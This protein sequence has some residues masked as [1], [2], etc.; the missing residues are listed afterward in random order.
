[1]SATT[2][3]TVSQKMSDLSTLVAWFESDEFVIE[4]AVEKYKEAE[5]LAR[6]IERDLESLKN[7]VTVLKQ[8]F[9][10]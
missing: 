7:E 10:A 9:D 8:K 3:K 1:M 4:Q 6:D 2:K 5:K